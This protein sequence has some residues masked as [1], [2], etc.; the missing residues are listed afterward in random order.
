[1]PFVCV[2]AC[3][4]VCVC[5][6]VHE[7]TSLDMCVLTSS[8]SPIYKFGMLFLAEKTFLVFSWTISNIFILQ[9]QLLILYNRL[10]QKS[11][12]YQVFELV[13]NILISNFFKGLLGSI[14]LGGSHTVTVR[15]GLRLPSSEGITSLIQNGLPTCLSIDAFGWKFRLVCWPEHQTVT[16]SIT[17]SRFITSATQDF[18]LVQRG[19]PYK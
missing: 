15:C 10:L 17:H 11:S 2:C 18:Q 16:S 8:Q 4:C 7:Y 19:L 12:L 9:F 13:H 14:S 6:Y 1:M 3:V 5:V